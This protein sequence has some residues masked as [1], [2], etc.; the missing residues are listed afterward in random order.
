[1]IALTLLVRPLA[2]QLLEPFYFPRNP[3]RVLDNVVI[4]RM[5]EV[6]DYVDVQSWELPLWE[7]CTVSP[8][9][10]SIG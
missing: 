8:R 6:G 7:W 1:M 3:S 2:S 4:E 10:V 9:L 5:I